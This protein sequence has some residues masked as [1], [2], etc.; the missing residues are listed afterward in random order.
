M[1]DGRPCEADGPRPV[2]PTTFENADRGKRSSKL[3]PAATCITGQPERD[4]S[5]IFNRGER[6]SEPDLRELANAELAKRY[7]ATAGK[8][9]VQPDEQGVATLLKQIH[10]SV[11]VKHTVPDVLQ[12]KSDLVSQNPRAFGRTWRRE[13]LQLTTDCECLLAWAAAPICGPELR[14]ERIEC[15]DAGNRHEAWRT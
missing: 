4:V 11:V 2:H 15:D 5:V 10:N 1:N 9:H 3:T 14:A 8:R 6:V 12:V 7:A 13:Q